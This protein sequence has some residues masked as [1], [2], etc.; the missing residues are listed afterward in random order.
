M[1]STGQKIEGHHCLRIFNA[2]R[3]GILPGETDGNCDRK[4]CSKKNDQKTPKT[5]KKTVRACCTAKS[6]KPNNAE[7]KLP[8]TRLNQ[9][10]ISQKVGI[11][12]DDGA[13]TGGGR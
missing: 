5:E 9:G 6:C 2:V 11:H 7:S 3:M 13:A 8:R 4:E 1:S 10:M 12:Q